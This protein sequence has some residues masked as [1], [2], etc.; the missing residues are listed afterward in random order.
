MSLARRHRETILAAQAAGAA[1]ATAAGPAPMPADGP[2]ATEYQTLLAGLGV[3]LAQLR[4][5]QAT[6]R[7]IE[8]KREMVGS[9]RA[10]VDGALA[11]AA[12]AGQAPQDEIVANMLIWAIDLA[13]WPWAFA[14]AEHM[15]RF[16]LRLPERFTRH[17]AVA[18]AEQV[19]EAG[20]A[21]VPAIDLETL[22]RFERLTGPHDMFDQVRAKLHKAIALAFTRA[23]AAF[24]PGA[25]SAV[26][27]GKRA[28]LSNALE[29]F[30]RALALDAGSG[31]KKLI[32]QTTRE[33]ANAA[34]PAA[35]PEN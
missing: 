24:D 2:V 4:E 15:L 17:P 1:A 3:H 30:E 16:G 5:I 8:A 22:L 12:E 18:I 31:V 9:Y 21:K 28:L 34:P 11:G 23:A 25:D 19:A 6:E 33:L 20:L 35:N 26:A 32:E 27:G 10:W 29:H 7:K 14:I 13:D